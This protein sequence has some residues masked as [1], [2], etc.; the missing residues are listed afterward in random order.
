MKARPRCF[1]PAF[2]RRGQIDEIKRAV[3]ILERLHVEIVLDVPYLFLDRDRMQAGF[4]HIADVLAERFDIALD[5]LASAL[6]VHA[7]KRADG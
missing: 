7:G 2:Q 6:A 5:L 4:E 3:G 1:A